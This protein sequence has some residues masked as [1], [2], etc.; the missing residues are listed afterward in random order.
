MQQ[1]SKLQGQS[2]DTLLKQIDEYRIIQAKVQQSLE[3]QIIQNL[4]DVVIRSDNDQ[5]FIIDK[6]EVDGLLSRLKSIEGVNFSEANFAKAIAK[7]GFDVQA[8]MEKRGGFDLTAVIAVVKNLLDDRVPA[9]ENIFQIDVQRLLPRG[10]RLQAEQRRK[11]ELQLE[12]A[13]LET[14]NTTT[15]Q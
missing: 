13:I 14:M 11:K 10:L 12:S 3:S 7:A 9:K 4:I 5:D 15:T 1:L 8:V 2:V 6:N